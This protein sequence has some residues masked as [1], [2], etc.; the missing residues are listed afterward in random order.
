MSRKSPPAAEDLT[1]KNLPSLFLIIIALEFGYSLHQQ[2]SSRSE[3]REAIQK[4]IGEIYIY[5]KEESDAHFEKMEKLIRDRI[6]S[7]ATAHI[8]AE[9]LRLQIERDA[10]ER[11][12]E[13]LLAQIRVLRAIADK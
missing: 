1:M 9:L 7:E 6:G 12:R 5:P 3:A 11:Q 10:D 4:M 13:M 2:A 8:D